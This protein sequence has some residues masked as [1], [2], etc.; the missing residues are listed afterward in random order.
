METYKGHREVGSLENFNSTL[1]GLENT[2]VYEWHVSHT[3]KGCL[4][5]TLDL[6]G[7]GKK[8]RGIHSV[9]MEHCG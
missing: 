2:E 3:L 5:S 6:R 8:K 7:I 9:P 1:P 4:A